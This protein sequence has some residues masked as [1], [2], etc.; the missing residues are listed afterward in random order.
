M[1]LPQT[2]TA[3]ARPRTP[4]RRGSPWSTGGYSRRHRS[5]RSGHAPSHLL[6]QPST[7]TVAHTAV[8]HQTATRNVITLLVER[9]ISTHAFQAAEVQEH[10]ALD[11]PPQEALRI[12][13]Q[14]CPSMEG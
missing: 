14:A 6:D 13:W 9:I 4:V 11:S 2:C 3:S 8:Q 10:R 12:G 5:L 1:E 7:K